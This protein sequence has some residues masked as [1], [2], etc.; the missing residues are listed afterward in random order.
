[1]F[2]YLSCFLYNRFHSIQFPYILQKKVNN[3]HWQGDQKSMLCFSCMILP[4]ATY[5]VVLSIMICITFSAP[6]PSQHSL[7]LEPVSVVF[8]L[9]KASKDLRKTTWSLQ[10]TKKLMMVRL[11]PSVHP[12]K[13]MV[14]PY[15]F[16]CNF[17]S[18]TTSLA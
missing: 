14:Q 9:S 6:T 10:E 18:S 16:H 3:M 2:C 5:A 17:C 4:A 7:A 1:M 15:C 11:L 13:S 12:S 8:T